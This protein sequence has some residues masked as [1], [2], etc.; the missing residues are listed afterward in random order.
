MTQV[1][2]DI[3]F[4]TK[5]KPEELLNLTDTISSTDIQFTLEK[6][7]NNKIPFLDIMTELTTDKILNTCLYIKPF[8]SRH[9]I[10]WSS[11][12]TG[13]ERSNCAANWNDNFVI[14]IEYQNHSWYPES[15][16]RSYAECKTSLI[17]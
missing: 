16:C 7:V 5:L 1:L 10:P 14:A 4:L 17:M 15:I 12:T 2:D 11:N 6:P 8:H 9:I 13:Q 3:F